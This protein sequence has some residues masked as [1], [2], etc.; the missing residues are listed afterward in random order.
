MGEHNELLNNFRNQHDIS[1]ESVIGDVRLRLDVLYEGISYNV[2]LVGNELSLRPVSVLKTILSQ[3]PVDLFDHS[4]DVGQ[5]TTIQL[6][7][8]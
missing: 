6:C 1:N 4:S 2:S 5:T 3:A 8:A 7:I